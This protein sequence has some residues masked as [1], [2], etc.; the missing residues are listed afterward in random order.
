MDKKNAIDK[1]ARSEK[2]MNSKE[3]RKKSFFSPSE[4]IIVQ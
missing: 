2:L 4:Q 3:E 1:E